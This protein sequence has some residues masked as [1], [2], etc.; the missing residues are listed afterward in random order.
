M[1]IYP[2]IDKNVYDIFNITDFSSLG[3]I[4]S[5]IRIELGEDYK[6]K[7]R[8]SFALNKANDIMDVCFKNQEL[9][10]RIILWDKVD[11]SDLLNPVL[12]PIKSHLKFKKIEDES[13]ILYYYFEKFDF[14]EIESLVKS[15]ICFELGVEPSINMTCFY[16]NFETPVL[17]N[18]YD[19]RGLDIVK[20][21]LS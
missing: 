17:L 3:N 7:E 8:I 21:N 18:I 2:E 1:I 13:L 4:E 11:D 20:G 9:F 16:F 14:R 5:K 19:D 15:S 6:S 10:L 12:E